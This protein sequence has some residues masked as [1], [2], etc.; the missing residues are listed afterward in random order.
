MSHIHYGKATAKLAANVKEPSL[1]FIVASQQIE[2]TWKLSLAEGRFVIIS[3]HPKTKK[4]TLKQ[5]K[6]RPLYK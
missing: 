4:L 2:Q 3:Q 1:R 5:F 6:S